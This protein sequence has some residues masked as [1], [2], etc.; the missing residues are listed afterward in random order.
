LEIPGIPIGLPEQDFTVLINETGIV[1]E[2]VPQKSWPKIRIDSTKGKEDFTIH[3]SDNSVDALVLY[4]RILFYLAKAGECHIHSPNLISTRI[5]L[6]SFSPSEPELLYR[7]K[8]ARKLKCIE[9]V[10]GGPLGVPPV[11]QRDEIIKLEI[12]F[13]GITEG[14]AV[15]RSETFTDRLRPSEINL[16]QPPFATPGLFSHDVD[17]NLPPQWDTVGPVKVVIKKAELANPRVLDQIREGANEPIQVRFVVWDHQIHFRFEEFANQPREQ[18][19]QRLEEFKQELAREEPQELVD[20]VSESLQFKVTSDEAVKIAFGWLYW[21]RFPDRYCPQ[22]PEFDGRA[23][24]WRVPI[25]LVYCSGEGG[26]VGEV[27]VDE[28][29]GAIVEHTPVEEMR[30]QGR[31]VAEKIKHAR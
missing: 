1:L 22:E 9:N 19:R 28:N 2:N 21:N 23:A 13:Q 6:S 15:I 14:E 12:I 5:E 24:C 27:V 18:L 7:A 11:I 8:L 4:T 26:P 16:D 10:L 29:T 30:S 20:L 3:P 25:H 31:A 17:L